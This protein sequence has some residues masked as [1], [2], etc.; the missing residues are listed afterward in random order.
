[1]DIVEEISSKFYG[2]KPIALFVMGKYTTAEINQ[3]SLYT[4]DLTVVL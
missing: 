3:L 2:V 1:M 4:K